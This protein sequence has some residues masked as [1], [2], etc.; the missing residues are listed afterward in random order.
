MI[1][2]NVMAIVIVMFNMRNPTPFLLLNHTLLY[3]ILHTGCSSSCINI[4]CSREHNGV[5]EMSNIQQ[6]QLLMELPLLGVK[7]MLKFTQA[8]S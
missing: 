7:F 8:S 6:L 5:L 3:S 1:F 4:D 2:I